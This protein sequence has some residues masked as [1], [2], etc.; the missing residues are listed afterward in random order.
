MPSSERINDKRTLSRRDLLKALTALGGAAA[1]SSIVPSQWAKPEVGVGV[2]PAHAQGT[3]S[4]T[5]GYPGIVQEDDNVDATLMIS[6]I[7]PAID[8]MCSAF[9]NGVPLNVINTKTDNTGE[10]AVTFFI[11]PANDSKPFRTEW[12]RLDNGQAGELICF[13]EANIEE[14][15]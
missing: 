12:R 3:F 10:A 14:N 5:C 9:I 1:A 6:P 13:A 11:P 7:T 2:L 15:E 4:A 8:V